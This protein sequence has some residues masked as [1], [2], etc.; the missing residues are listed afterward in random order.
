METCVVT[1]TVAVPPVCVWVGG[2]CIIAYSVWLTV[3]SVPIEIRNKKRTT[4]G[5]TSIGLSQCCLRI[6]FMGVQWLT[7]VNK[8][9]QKKGKKFD[10]DFSSH[11]LQ[12]PTVPPSGTCWNVQLAMFI[13]CS[14]PHLY[15]SSSLH[16]S[17]WSNSKCCCWIYFS[18]HKLNCSYFNVNKKWKTLIIIINM[19]S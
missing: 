7:N 2:W 11:R 5:S 12:T 3:T 13:P 15:R 18:R 1:T 19:K 14:G 9:K 16:H 4:D 8:H 6:E 17:R 10:V